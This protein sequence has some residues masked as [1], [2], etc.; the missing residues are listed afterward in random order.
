[1]EKKYLLQMLQQTSL[2][3]DHGDT[4][5]HNSV[6]NMIPEKVAAWDDEFSNF[7]KTHLQFDPTRELRRLVTSSTHI[8]K[9]FDKDGAIMSFGRSALTSSSSYDHR[10]PTILPDDRPSSTST[11]SSSSPGSFLSAAA[12]SIV[13][14]MLVGVAAVGSGS[15]AF[16]SSGMGYPALGSS[17]KVLNPAVFVG[18]YEDNSSADTAHQGGGAP[19]PSTTSSSSPSTNEMSTSEGYIGF[20]N[21]STMLD[22]VRQRDE[23][24]S[25]RTLFLDDVSKDDFTLSF[26][27]KIDLVDTSASARAIMPT[28]LP[29][30]ELVVGLNSLAAT[31]NNLKRSVPRPATMIDIDESGTHDRIQATTPLPLLLDQETSYMDELGD[32]SIASIKPS[33]ASAP[34][35]DHENAPSPSPP[36][37][38][39]SANTS[40]LFKDISSVHNPG[41]SETSTLPNSGDI[42][43]ALDKKFGKDDTSNAVAAHAAQQHNRNSST[44]KS[45]L[46][47]ISGV[48]VGQQ[49]TDLDF[50]GDADNESD[51]AQQLA[52][53]K[54]SAG[55]VSNDRVSLM[56]T[57]ITNF[58]TG[59]NNI[60]FPPL[61]YPM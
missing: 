6:K 27:D 33:R 40:S 16:Y 7:I 51:F 59:G 10:R 52:A 47:Y 53:W 2:S 41:S 57:I 39:S 11:A 61:D 21:S 12:S 25:R 22:F 48:T 1:M 5:A 43:T 58:W 38:P 24:Q 14:G 28:S 26:S 35:A 32:A 18:D 20:L 23:L 29:V 60:T 4:L 8:R 50:E 44:T 56:K 34:F 9:I 37:V 36:L 42:F 54:S 15:A 49:Y 13:S 30:S 19:F 17:P 31:E 3:S 45:E 46:N 55:V